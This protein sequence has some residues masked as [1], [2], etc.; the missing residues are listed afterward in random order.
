MYTTIGALISFYI[1]PFCLSHTL[2]KFHN[3]LKVSN[4]YECT[5]KSFSDEVCED[6]HQ[7]CS[8]W[9]GIYECS[10]SSY[11]L[12]TCPKSCEKCGSGKNTQIF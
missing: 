9:A 10:T 12:Q 2:E 11:M 7:D 3:S 1:I 6:Y 8:Y 5:Y 4:D